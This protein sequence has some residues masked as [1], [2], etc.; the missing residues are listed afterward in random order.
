MVIARRKSLG[1]PVTILA[2]PDPA[3]TR[4]LNSAQGPARRMRGALRDAPPA[5]GR[6]NHRRRRSP[7][8]RCATKR[9]GSSALPKSPRDITARKAAERE[10]DELLAREREVR[11]TA[12]LLNQV[13][14]RLLA[15]L[16]REK[17]AQEVADIARA[18]IGAELRC[19]CSQGAA[20]GYGKGIPAAANLS[21]LREAF[22]ARNDLGDFIAKLP[23]EGV[24]RNDECRPIPASGATWPRR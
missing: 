12:E 6:G 2:S 10:R 23:D 3:S 14:P 1:K 17:L 8:R 4:C 22:A 16:D 24:V 11:R 20:A 9:D 13:G 7:S 18:L 5:E 19:V 15:Q 21:G